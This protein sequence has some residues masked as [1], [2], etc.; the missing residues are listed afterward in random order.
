MPCGD[1]YYQYGNQSYAYS[2]AATTTQITYPS[3]VT[4]MYMNPIS[5]WGVD[6]DIYGS[7]TTAANIY[8][9]YNPNTINGSWAYVVTAAANET[10]EEKAV[11]EVQ[12]AALATKRAAAAEVK[13]EE[14]LLMCL[15]DAQREQY[16]K[17][18]YIEINTDT[19]NYRIK[20]GWSKNIEKIAK[21]GK[22]ECYYCI[23]PTIAVPEADNMLA[24]KLMLETDEANF[25]LKA[26]RWPF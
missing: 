17:V 25:L 16:L 23:H 24:Q 20:K 15:S 18:G 14:L 3:S 9:N 19:A 5:N 11:R 26:N 10:P 21:D 4:P 7:S 2:N 22:T 13:A 6:T 8:Y 1:Q 12:E